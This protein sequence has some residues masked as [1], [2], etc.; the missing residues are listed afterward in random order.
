MIGFEAEAARRVKPKSKVTIEKTQNMFEVTD[1]KIDPID[2]MYEADVV[3]T[4]HWLV[5]DGVQPAIPEN[6]S[7]ESDTSKKDDKKNTEEARLSNTCILKDIGKKVPKTEHVE[8]RTVTTHTVPLEHQVFFR[9]IMETVMCSDEAKRTMALATLK[10][11][12]G[13]QVLVPRFSNAFAEGVRCN[14]IQENVAFLIY[15][16]RITDSLVL[17]P[18]VNLEKHVC[19]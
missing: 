9:E 7:K 6:P 10:S 8:V 2:E 17:N 14:L 4:P 3:I 18:N 11:D 5:I 1:L 16:M 19:F 12:P 13:L 15:L